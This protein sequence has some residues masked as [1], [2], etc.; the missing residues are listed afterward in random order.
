MVRTLDQLCRT[1]H[2]SSCICID[3][4]IQ[5]ADWKMWRQQVTNQCGPQWVK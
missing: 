3:L 5:I 2:K 4:Q 1:S